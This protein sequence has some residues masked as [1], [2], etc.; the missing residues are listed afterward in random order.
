MPFIQ[1]A[2]VYCNVSGNSDLRDAWKLFH[3]RQ[4]AGNYTKNIEDAYTVN[5]WKY[6]I[7]GQSDNI[8]PPRKWDCGV[9]AAEVAVTNFYNN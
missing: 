2:I 1:S 7:F 8:H 4:V 6:W 5:L 9:A 3:D